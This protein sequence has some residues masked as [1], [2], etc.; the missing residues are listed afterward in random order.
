MDGPKSRWL[1][2]EGRQVGELPSGW[3]WSLEGEDIV[4]GEV[5]RRLR[6]GLNQHSSTS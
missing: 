2:F 4:E 1:A 3:F 6:S 5:G